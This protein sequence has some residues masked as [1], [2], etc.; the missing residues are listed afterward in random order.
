M[1]IHIQDAPDQME[2]SA[3]SVKRW[4]GD[5]PKI[6]HA[7]YERSPGQFEESDNIAADPENNWDEDN[8]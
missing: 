5:K 7:P 2:V 3:V 4:V 1:T 8:G 6:T